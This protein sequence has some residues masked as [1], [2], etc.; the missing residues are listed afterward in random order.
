[1]TEGKRQFSAFS[2]HLFE[3]GLTKLRH[4]QQTKSEIFRRE[5]N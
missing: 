4:L 2:G 3:T 5:R 1:M